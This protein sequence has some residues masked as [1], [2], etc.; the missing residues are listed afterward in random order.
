MTFKKLPED[1]DILTYLMLQLIIDEPN[2][3]IE[4]V[5]EKDVDIGTYGLIIEYLES[6]EQKLYIKLVRDEEGTLSSINLRI[7]TTNLF[8]E[9]KGV[10]FED[11]WKE[12]HKITSLPMTDKEPAKKY[13]KSLK[14]YEKTLAF[15][16]IQAYFDS[17]DKR[18]CKKAR[19][20]LRDKNFNDYFEHE[21]QDWTTNH[22]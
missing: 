6:L 9:E 15:E 20:Y 21:V 22:L 17:I 8:P 13:Y 1:L 16:K 19:T 14:G 18:F 4:Y 11:F 2:E 10:S 3:L 7:K 5:N 12:Y